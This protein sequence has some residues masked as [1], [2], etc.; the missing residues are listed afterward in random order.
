[1]VVAA[2]VAGIAGILLATGTAAA[3]G[4]GLLETC[5]AATLLLAMDRCEE[6]VGAAAAA[7]CVRGR[8]APAVGSGAAALAVKMLVYALVGRTTEEEPK[9]VTLQLLW[10]PAA[11]VR[12]RFAVGG[13]LVMEFF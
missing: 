8:F 3:A 11:V 2:V 9:L 7:A 10:P 6:E 1:M 12:C 4:G 5:C 13:L